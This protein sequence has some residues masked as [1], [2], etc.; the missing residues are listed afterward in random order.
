MTLIEKYNEFNKFG[1]LIG[2]N[3]TITKPGE[4]HYHIIITE[5]LLATPVAAHGGV[6]AAMMDGVLGIPALSLAIESKKV[7]STVEFKINFLAPAL[8]YDKLLG[9]GRVEHKGNRIMVSSGEIIC[10]N[11]NNILI[12]KAMGTFNAYPAEKAGFNI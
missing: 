5:E 2:M 4:V 6:I 9:I 1:K 11:R 7:V 8:L 10:T 12:A 3:F